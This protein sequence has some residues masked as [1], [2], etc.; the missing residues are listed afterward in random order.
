MNKVQRIITL[1]MTSVL[2][3]LGILAPTP[4]YASD[5]FKE[6]CTG[7]DTSA[8]CKASTTDTSTKAQS[9]VGTVISIILMVAGVAAV[10]MIIVGGIRYTLSGGDASAI[11]SA[12]NTILYSV[13]GLIVAILAFAIVNFVVAQFSK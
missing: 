13:I 1:G 8:V 12:K 11:Q 2:L 9:M 6:G 3:A 4:A 7:N 5:V 10:I